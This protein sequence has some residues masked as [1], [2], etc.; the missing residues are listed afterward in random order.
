MTAY[1]IAKVALA[2]QGKTVVSTT[3]ELVLGVIMAI[4]CHDRRI[5]AHWLQVC[6]PWDVSRV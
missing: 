4:M 3:L 6:I 2:Y 1:G 5:G